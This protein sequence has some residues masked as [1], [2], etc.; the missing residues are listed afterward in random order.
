MAAMLRSPQVTTVQSHML[1][2]SVDQRG[3]GGANDTQDTHKVSWAD[4]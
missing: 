1:C 4:Q 3:R 2:Q